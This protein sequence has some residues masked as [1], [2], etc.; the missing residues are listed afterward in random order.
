MKNAMITLQVPCQLLGMK[1]LQTRVW[2]E[3]GEQKRPFIPDSEKH[4][5]AHFWTVPMKLLCR[6]SWCADIP[7]RNSMSQVSAILR[8]E[9]VTARKGDDSGLEHCRRRS[10]FVFRPSPEPSVGRMG[11]FLQRMTSS[12]SLAKDSLK[13]ASSP[14]SASRASTRVAAGGP[15]LKGNK[16]TTKFAMHNADRDECSV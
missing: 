16:H 10:T 7:P 1:A 13:K 12:K 9:C 6:R 3:D 15:V 11:G 8:S 4:Q 14:L 2:K 5:D